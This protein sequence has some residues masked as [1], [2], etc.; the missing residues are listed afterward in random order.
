MAGFSFFYFINSLSLLL[1]SISYCNSLS[2]SSAA[3]EA[4]ES[5][6]EWRSGGGHG[7]RL[8]RSESRCTAGPIHHNVVL[9]LACSLPLSITASLGRSEN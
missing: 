5:T 1:A 8:R 4:E 3:G 9:A 7:A 2:D 6:Q